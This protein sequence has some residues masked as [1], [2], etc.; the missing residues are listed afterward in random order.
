[1]AQIVRICLLAALIYGGFAATLI[2]GITPWMH[3]EGYLLLRGNVTMAQYQKRAVGSAALGYPLLC[4][5]FVVAQMYRKKETALL[6]RKTNVPTRS[7]R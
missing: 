2:Y 6:A 4:A 1:M 5:L 3:K 7:A